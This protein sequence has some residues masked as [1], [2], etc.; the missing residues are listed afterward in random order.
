[1]TSTVLPEAAEVRN[2]CG[3]AW[4]RPRVERTHAVHNPSTGEVIGWT[5]MCG[6]REV[7]EA[8]RAAAMA[9]ASWSRTPV[10]RR[11]EALFRYRALLEEHREELS[12]LITRENGKTLEEARGDVKRGIEV[13]DFACG[14]AHLSKGESLHEIAPHIDG[15]TMREPVGVC[16]G[17]TPFNFPAM[18]PMWMFPIAIACGNAFILKPSEKVPFTA[19]RFAELFQEAGLQEGVFNVVHGGRDVVDALC[20]H[21][22]V[23]AV[24]FVGSSPIARHVYALACGH[25]K[26]VQ[27]AGGAKNVLLVMPDAEPD[28]TLRA[29]MSSA[30]GCAGQRCMAGSV[31]MAVG[32][33]AD[34][35]R[36]QVADAMARLKV[37]DTSANDA[38]E[39][40]PVI[41]G[42]AR[43][44]IRSEIERAVEAGATRTLGDGDR[45]LD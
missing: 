43:Q 44:R 15:L 6:A 34:A 3:G 32:E 9:Y 26:R 4:I 5:P 28:A 21:P 25:G 40:G 23:A 17:I 37:D 14:I 45:A 19:C 16:A 42:G 18:V 20:S 13:V 27:A 33:T 38:A 2:F 12:R 36:D 39:M 1:M 11:A 10:P 30:F 29:V 8:V 24:S 31:L 7:D 41:D 22:G 35:V